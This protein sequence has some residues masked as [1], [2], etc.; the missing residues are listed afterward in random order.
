MLFD[1]DNLH[2]EK[3]EPGSITRFGCDANVKSMQEEELFKI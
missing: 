2:G 3:N 1:G